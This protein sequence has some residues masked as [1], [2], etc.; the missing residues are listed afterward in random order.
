MIRTEKLTRDYGGG[1]GIL[2]LDLHVPKGKI[3]GY[4]GPNGAGKTTTIKL[5]CGLVRPTSGRAFIND[6][7]VTA[8]NT[9][10]I[11]R[12]V[13]Y[14]P[15]IFGVYDQMSVWEYL[16]FFCAAYRIKPKD[17][18]ERIDEALHL[19]DAAYM[20]DYQVASLSRGMRQRIGLAKTLLH[21]P[22]VLILD[23]P[24]GGLDPKARIERRNTISRL[25]HL[26][27]TILL[28]SHI[29]PELASVCDL[30]GILKHGRLVAQGTVAEI[31]DTL[32]EK[33]VLVLAVDGGTPR[34][35]MTCLNFPNVEEAIASGNEVRL[36]FSGT[37]GEIADLNAA[38][39]AKGVRVTSL[40]EAEADLEQVFLTVTGDREQATEESAED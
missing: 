21:D 22:E 4:I 20:L 35:V 32:R 27:K 3:F 37:R 39:V 15:D 8:A 17:R 11:K 34:A 18:K 38:L 36:V 14:L 13:G 31:T 7:E 12:L 5:L 25:S 24:A 23:E 1:R 6:V 26:G 40:K 2:D 10:T 29:L 9:Q 28:S 16:D 33:L 30:V 19:T